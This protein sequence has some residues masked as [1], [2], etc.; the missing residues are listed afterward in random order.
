MI[1]QPDGPVP[2]EIMIVGEAPGYDEERLGKPFMG[3]SGSE[4]NKMLGEAGISRGGCFVTN[5]CRLRPPHN[6]ITHFIAKSKK[7]ITND[8]KLYQGKWVKPPIIDGGNQLQ[9]EISLVKPNIIIALGGTPLWALTGLSGIQRWRGSMLYYTDSKTGASTKLIPTYHPAAILRQWE[10]RSIAVQDLR[11][12]ALFRDGRDYPKVAQK[13]TI[14]PSFATA[15][16]LLNQL[17]GRLQKGP[18][19]LSFD[20]E[21]RQG[22]IDCAGLAWSEEEALCIPFMV[23]H[24]AYWSE[25]EEATLVWYLYRILTHQNVQVI[26][27]NLLYDAQYTYRRWHFIPRVHQDTMVS[28]HVAFPGLPKKLDFQ[29]SL[30]CKHYVQWKKERTAWVKEGG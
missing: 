18:L 16:E 19:R 10:W 20:I 30:L 8:H 26:G 22:H 24:T 9:K 3:A 7:E 13:F 1:C 14:Q 11:R 4:L 23:G 25:D 28:W 12:A 15:L 27:Q 29:A 17:L 2:A 6:D 21:T 5:V